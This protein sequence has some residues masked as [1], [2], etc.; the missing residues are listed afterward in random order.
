[1]KMPDSLLFDDSL[2]RERVQQIKWLALA[3]LITMLVVLL[4][5]AAYRA[6]HPWLAWT[7]AFAEAATVGAIADWFAVTALF[8]HPLGLPIPHTAIIPNN[9]DRL[10]S[11]LGEFVEHNF[12]TPR[13]VIARLEHR[14]LALAA[15]DW[16]VQPGNS[17]QAARRI[18]AQLPLLMDRFGDADVQRA[19]EKVIRPQLE[20]LNLAPVV[21]EL[22]DLLTLEG[23]HQALLNHGIESLDAWLVANRP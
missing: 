10:G 8:R 15:A 3:L 13:N 14:D 5:S 22:L 21:G 1:M 11:N 23:R 4:A 19:V 6:A 16:L 20:S 2:K 9:K 12:L 18:C 7:Y 17:K